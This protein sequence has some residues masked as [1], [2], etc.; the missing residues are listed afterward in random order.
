M[1][2]IEYRFIEGTDRKAY[3]SS[4]GK[5]FKRKA[6]YKGNRI[7]GRQLK[8]WSEFREV[9]PRLGYWGYFAVT[10]P[11]RKDCSIHRL[12][13]EAFIPN[14][15]NKPFVDHID[16]NKTNNRVENLRWVTNK[17]NCNNPNTKYKHVYSSNHRVWS[18]IQ[19]F[20]PKTNLRTLVFSN[21][22]E[23]SNW[24]SPE[25]KK[26]NLVSLRNVLNKKIT[27]RNYFWTAKLVTG[28]EYQKI[29]KT[30]ISEIHGTN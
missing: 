5:V 12:V 11:Y 24:I 30:V 10:I 29:L 27:Y 19:G 6:I 17:E 16:G 25:G 15:E 3:V 4:D 26:I 7:T 20:N 28:E 14:P 13:A 23:A 8:G 21:L 1:E 22:R 18:Y 2:E 9:K